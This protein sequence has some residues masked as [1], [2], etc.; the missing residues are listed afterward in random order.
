MSEGDAERKKALAEHHRYC[1]SPDR[2]DEVVRRRV[3]F[4]TA[5]GERSHSYEQLHSTRL[6]VAQDNVEVVQQLR[7]EVVYA[8][9]QGAPNYR[10]AMEPTTK[11]RS[12]KNTTE[13]SE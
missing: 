7:D 13:V 8:T 5:H 6:M 3:L 1:I 11:K 12:G 9:V 2:L 4:R 10:F